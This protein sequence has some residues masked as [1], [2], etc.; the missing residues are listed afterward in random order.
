MIQCSRH[1][2]YS[3]RTTEN[4]PQGRTYRRNLKS[5]IHNTKIQ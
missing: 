2:V 1:C 3:H 5:M 4:N